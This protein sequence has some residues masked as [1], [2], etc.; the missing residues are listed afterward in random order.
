[1]WRPAVLLECLHCVCITQH[2]LLREL[3]NE[4]GH[5]QWAFLTLQFVYV[6]AFNRSK[7]NDHNHTQVTGA[8]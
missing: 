1:M 3:S 2:D 4:L 5:M 8:S 6:R 7:Q